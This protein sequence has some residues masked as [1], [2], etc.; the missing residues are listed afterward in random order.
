MEI[1]KVEI[2]ENE[3]ENK[4]EVVVKIDRRT[5]R[6]APHRWLA[7]GKYD[8]KPNS[9]SYFRDYYRSQRSPTECQYCH[10]VFTGRDCLYKH[11][12]RSKKCIKLRAEIKAALASASSE[13]SDEN[14]FLAAPPTSSEDESDEN[15]FLAE[16]NENFF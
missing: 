2:D 11:G 3:V 12:V 8:S 10:L 15:F 16:P 4:I 1:P 6:T 9:P 13:E 5:I 7:N 14:F